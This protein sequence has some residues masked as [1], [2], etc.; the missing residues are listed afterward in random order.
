MSFFHLVFGLKTISLKLFTK[1][2]FCR[3][4]SVGKKS[5]GKTSNIMLH[6][7]NEPVQIILATGLT[8]DMDHI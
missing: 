1:S 6:E 3:N 2:E 7:E 5:A 4:K 8:M